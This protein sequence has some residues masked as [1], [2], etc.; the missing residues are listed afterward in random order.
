ML[1]AML[2][3]TVG[4]GA[5]SAANARTLSWVVSIT[6]QNVGTA[7]ANVG[8]DFYA[9]NSATAIHYALPD[10][11]AGAAASLYIGSVTDVPAGFR[12]SA[13]M[14]STQQLVATVVQF[15]SNAAGETVKVRMLSNGFGDAD[16]SSTFLLA[17]VMANNTNR[18]TIF[19]V[20]NIESETV[21]AT[22]KFYDATGALA[23]TKTYDIPAQSTKYI[24]MDVAAQTGLPT[25]FNGSA[26]VTAVMK[27]DGTTAARVVATENEYWT[28]K[29]DAASFEGIPASKA[30]QTLYLATGLCKNGGLRTYYA[31]QNSSLT[32]ATNIT[33][34]YYNPADGSLKATDGPYPIGAGQKK[35]IDTCLPAGMTG[36]SGSA[37]VVSDT[38]PIVAIGRAQ[39][40]TAGVDPNKKDVFTAFLG[41][42][43]GYAKLALPF[44]RWGS[45]ARYTAATNY[46]GVQRSYLAIQNVSTVSGK[47]NVK[48]MDKDGVLAA[49]EVLTIAAG[50][51][52][53]SNPSSAGALGKNGMNAGEFGYYPGG[54]FGGGVIIEVDGS[55]PTARFIAVARVQNPGMG[56]DYNGVPIP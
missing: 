37:K 28:T 21:T 50:A 4:I 13:V 32:T 30:S 14:S 49:T 40:G 56:E 33:V 35:S 15:H 10:L 36:W 12:G 43:S 22:F 8:V 2:F 5:V 6:Y 55:T 52:G 25:T 18:T 29:F 44:V 31:V 46:G 19:S 23:S 38:T 26:I 39:D 51:K 45:D 9:E 7:A 53:Q 11:N 54:L 41:E 42:P 47:V 20:Q 27:S 3:A 24:E 34:T 17:T 48:Y 16:A 1:V